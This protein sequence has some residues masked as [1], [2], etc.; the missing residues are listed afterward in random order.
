MNWIDFSILII[1]VLAFLNGYRR[2]LFKEMTTFLGL[3]IGIIVSVNYSDALALKLQGKIGMS[4]SVLYVLC[5]I[6]IFVVTL[7][8]LKILGHYFYQMVK[9]ASLKPSDKI[10]GGI[11]GVF[12]G[13]VVLSLLFLLFIFPT[14]FRNLDN[15]I[16][17]S[18][19]AGTVRAIVPFV[20]DNTT[21]L[22]P[23]SG[24][25][26]SEVQQG[27]LFD[28][29]KEYAESPD[30]ALGDKTLIGM[31]DQDIATLD[32][33]NQCFNKAKKQEQQ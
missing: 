9:L 4:A 21:F 31:T 30:K 25:F 24:E 13:L 6:L 15:S 10:G 18:T 8:V 28:K 16:E 2:G 14:P 7:A 20:Y 11:F 22:H 29:T 3:L 32:K 26:L 12:K 27:I 5:F 23:K 1:A 19:M 33:L 17:A